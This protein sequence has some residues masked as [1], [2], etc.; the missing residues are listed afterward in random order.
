MSKYRIHSGPRFFWDWDSPTSRE[1]AGFYRRL[2]SI[3][4]VCARL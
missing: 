2:D 4:Y 3:F 1:C